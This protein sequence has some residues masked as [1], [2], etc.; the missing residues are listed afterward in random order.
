MEDN[1][2]KVEFSDIA[3]KQLKKMDRQVAS[4]IFGYIEKNINNNPNPRNLGKSL[5]GNHQGKWRYRVGDYRI[6]CEIKDEVVT[7]VV[8]E[9]GHRKNIYI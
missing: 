7:I 4:L 9:I 3:L 2:Y 8:V 5:V 6:L 1:K